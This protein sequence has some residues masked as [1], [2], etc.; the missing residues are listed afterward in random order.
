M[1]TETIQLFITA[2]RFIIIPT[3]DTTSIIMMIINH[4]QPTPSN[5]SSPSSLTCSSSSKT[6]ASRMKP[7]FMLRLVIAARVIVLTQY[8]ETKY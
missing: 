2:T 3:F 4:H 8:L 7:S 5:Q 1:K 6:G